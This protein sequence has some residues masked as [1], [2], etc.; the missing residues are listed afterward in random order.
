MQRFYSAV[1]RGI[2]IHAPARGATKEW[3]PVD[4]RLPISIHAPARGATVYKQIQ[5]ALHR[6]QSTLPRGER[7]D[8]ILP[9]RFIRRFQSTLPRGERLPC[10]VC[11]SWLISDFNPRSREG[12]DETGASLP[13][14]LADFNP[15]SREGSDVVIV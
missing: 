4:E 13:A 5:D 8:C 15:R 7:Q 11:V 12:S 3:T 10:V 1:L 2:S 14:V 6:F 9:K